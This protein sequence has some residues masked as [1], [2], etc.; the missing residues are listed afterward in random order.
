MIVG[1]DSEATGSEKDWPEVIIESEALMVEI[2]DI[3][4]F[5]GFTD[6]S[7]IKIRIV[8][9]AGLNTGFHV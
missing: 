9:V 1:S 4:L 7:L 5:L 6:I 2:D 3:V 8:G